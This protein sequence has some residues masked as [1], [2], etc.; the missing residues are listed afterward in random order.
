MLTSSPGRA[1]IRCE[2]WAPIARAKFSTA[3]IRR[4]K[5]IYLSMV[6]MG[7]LQFTVMTGMEEKQEK[8]SLCSSGP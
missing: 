4:N 7:A 2:I 1:I 5:S 6:I 8:G 3:T